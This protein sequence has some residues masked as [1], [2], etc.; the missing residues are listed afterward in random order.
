MIPTELTEKVGFE[1]ADVEH[2]RV[3]VQLP[4]HEQAEHGESAGDR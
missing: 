3:G 4:Q 1:Q 2:R